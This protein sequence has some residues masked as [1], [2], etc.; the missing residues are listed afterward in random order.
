[1]G[2]VAGVGPVLQAAVFRVGWLDRDM[3]LMAL[4]LV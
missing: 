1:M 3:G 2:A 4:P